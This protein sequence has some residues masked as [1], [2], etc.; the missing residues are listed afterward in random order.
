MVLLR[1]YR[2]KWY[3][4]KTRCFALHFCRRKRYV[5]NHFTQCAPKAAEFGE[6]MQNKGQG[7]YAVQDHSRSPDFWYKSIRVPVSD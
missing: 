5:F 2:R 4:A 3:I 1:E 6:I 7:H